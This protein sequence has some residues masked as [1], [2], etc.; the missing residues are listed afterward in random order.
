VSPVT[1][2]PAQPGVDGGDASDGATERNVWLASDAG[3]YAE[4]SPGFQRR[5]LTGRDMMIAMWRIRAGSGPTPYGN[6]AG[7]E[8]FGI[9]LRGSLDFRINGERRELG[10]GD[11]YWAPPGC[12]HGD[13]HFAGDAGSDECWIADIF[14]PPRE[15]YRNG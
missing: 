7:N 9:I 2:R 5:I 8:Q 13:S 4:S 3:A 1:R 15:D 10:P 14:S 12:D 11:V 6:H